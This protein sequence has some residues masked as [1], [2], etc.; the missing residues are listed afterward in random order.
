MNDIIAATEFEK[1]HEWSLDLQE[2][3]V[4]NHRQLIEGCV[5]NGLLRSTQL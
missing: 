4:D 2:V 1:K 3:S 5:Q